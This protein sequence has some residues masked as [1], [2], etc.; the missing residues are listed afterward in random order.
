MPQP[1]TAAGPDGGPRQGRS[2]AARLLLLQCVLI[3]GFVAL[4][5]G[6][7]LIEQKT[8]D[9]PFLAPDTF[10]SPWFP[11]RDWPPPRFDAEGR[12]YFR[13]RAE[14]VSVAKPAGVV[15][16]IAVGGSTTANKR[17]F[18]MGGVDFALALERRLNARG[19]G[20]RYEVLNAG[21]ESFSTAHVLV[22]LLLR[23]FEFQ[24]DVVVCMENINDLSANYY[25]ERV[26]ADYA[27]K[28]LDAEF[29]DPALESGR[30]LHG[31]LMRSRVL[32][33]ISWL[34][35]WNKTREHPAEDVSAGL[36]YFRRNLREIARA[37]REHGA[38]LVLLTQPCDGVADPS[39]SL[40][41]FAL[42]NR[43]IESVARECEVEFLDMHALFGH[44]RARF[45][46][47]VHY[48]PEGC[49]A[50]A[51]ILASRIDFAR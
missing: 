29:T 41:Q 1:T 19:D 43:E 13:H 24:P 40:E 30:T 22:N 26:S 9:R 17:A 28:Y 34:R 3:A 12:A 37:T 23:L 50:F 25:G 7:R 47:P 2:L 4:E 33:N 21:A 38:R 48:T 18:A 31:F 27:N 44:D 35:R 36:A 46:D 15:R 8:R 39:Y 16:V 42:Y 11:T 51:E 6:L 32:R 20:Q 49:E 45:V 5:L 14:P 10:V